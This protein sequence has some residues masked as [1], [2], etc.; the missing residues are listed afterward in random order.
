MAFVTRALVRGR[1]VAALLSVA[2]LSCTLYAISLYQLGVAHRSSQAIQIISEADRTTYAAMRA[3]REYVTAADGAPSSIALSELRRATAR[4]RTAG[5][6]FTTARNQGDIPAPVNQLLDRLTVGPIPFFFEAQELM[7]DV[8]AGRRKRAEIVAAALEMERDFYLYFEPFFNRAVRILA[9]SEDSQL[10]RSHTLSLVAIVCVLALIGAIGL[11]LFMP[12]E[13]RILDAQESLR[14]AREKAEAASFAKSEF[15]ANMSHEIRTPMNGVLGMAELLSRTRLDERQKDY[16][17]VILT[18]ATALL[19]IINDILDLS[20]LEAQ[21]LELDPVGFNLRSAIED[22]ATLMAPRVK[23]KGLELM[24]RF[25]PGV[26]EELVGDPGRIRQVITNLVGNA[27]KFTEHG[28]VLIDVD[29]SLV[30]GN[31][32]LRVSV[33]DTGIGVESDKLE[34]I[35][36][37]FEQA[38]SSASRRYSGTGLG[39]AITRRLIEAMGGTVGVESSVG[40]GSTFWFE[41]SLPVAR[42]RSTHL[43]PADLA[44]MRV[45][46]VDDLEVNRL[47]L[48]EQIESW[49]MV[50]DAAATGD[51]ALRLMREAAAAGKPFEVAILDGRMP[52][53]AGEE[54][55]GHIKADPAISDTPLI[56]LTSVGAPGDAAR[57]RGLGIA[58]Y[59]TKPAR[60]GLVLDTV[61]AVCGH[62]RSGTESAGSRPAVVSPPAPG[63]SDDV[64]FRVLLAEDSRLNATV[65][66]QMLEDFPCELVHAEDGLVAIERFARERFDLVLMDVSMPTM[67]GYEATQAVRSAERRMG[68][69][70]VPIIGLS[71]RAA[72]GD[73]ERCL[74]AGMDDVL[75]KPLHRELLVTTL[76]RWLEGREQDGDRVL[77]LA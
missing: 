11:F 56:L 77:S 2:I 30:E 15:L 72:A 55:A 27:V 43:P 31:S 38:D 33:T 23:E 54:L 45:L 58:G 48:R 68:G 49:G 21:K 62:N 57:L 6:A 10:R 18:S 26:P 61:A 16:A 39:L 28:Y 32:C 1:W 29:N 64:E 46:V 7:T 65:V 12:L 8:I 50:A 76:S 69:P 24:V 35:F 63:Q 42:R 73:R 52:G 14:A 19:K 47:V 5:I 13:N 74:A 59:L 17:D 4:Y 66:A 37:K 9:A 40:H 51:D 20:R 3:L 71:S 67:D 44:G 70:R 36:G 53:M 75:T 25:R 22:V 60:S 34:R 41:L